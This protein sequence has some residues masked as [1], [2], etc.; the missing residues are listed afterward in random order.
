[1]YVGFEVE[2]RSRIWGNG[3]VQ[4]GGMLKSPNGSGVLAIDLDFLKAEYVWP[5]VAC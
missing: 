1:V 5:V 4:V 2:W 3:G